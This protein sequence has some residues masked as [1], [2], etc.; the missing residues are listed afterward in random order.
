[1]LGD[2]LARPL[3]RNASDAAQH[4]GSLGRRQ[5]ACPDNGVA[6]AYA[7]A[8][9]GA[10]LDAVADADEAAE[11]HAGVR[12]V[13]AE[14]RRGDPLAWPS[15]RHQSAVGRIVDVRNGDEVLARL[16]QEHET[17]GAD[18]GEA[19]LLEH[20]QGVDDAEGVVEPT[21]DSGEVAGDHGRGAA[22]RARLGQA[23]VQIRRL[24]LLDLLHH[25]APPPV[26]LPRAEG[27]RVEV[28]DDGLG[29]QVAAGLQ[30][31]VRGAVRADVDLGVRPEVTQPLRRQRRVQEHHAAAGE[32]RRAR[33]RGPLEEAAAQAQSTA[34][35]M[36]FT[37]TGLA[38]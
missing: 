8:S 23:L 15:Q 5:H 3:P 13:P 27:G 34:G 17:C 31:P 11:V 1:M 21:L 16:E 18:D 36:M 7:D 19:L 25:A 14:A 24:L 22:P 6:D 9:P 29:R 20:V 32:R 30:E 4:S 38:A 28:A 2:T 10:G 37:S 35:V 33:F 26:L 12:H